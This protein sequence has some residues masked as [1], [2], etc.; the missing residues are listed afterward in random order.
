MDFC[1]AAE[2]C[3]LG[4]SAL[5]FSVPSCACH[6]TRSSACCMLCPLYLP[7]C[8]LRRSLNPVEIPTFIFHFLS[9]YGV[10]QRFSNSVSPHT[11]V[12]RAVARCVAINLTIHNAIQQLNTK[13]MIALWI[14]EEPSRI[15]LPRVVDLY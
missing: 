2:C 3:S 4:I 5:R 14:A 13:S 6:F 10:Q 11:D 15:A 8:I 7:N 12:S 1:W 9:L